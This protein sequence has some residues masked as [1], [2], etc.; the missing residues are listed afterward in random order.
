MYH[1]GLVANFTTNNGCSVDS[2][3]TAQR[4]VP[5]IDVT[6]FTCNLC[7]H[8]WHWLDGAASSGFHRW[9]G[10]QPELY[11]HTFAHCVAAERNATSGIFE[12][13]T[14]VCDI[15]EAVF[16]CKTGSCINFL[17]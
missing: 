6:I 4:T 15:R 2:E 12:W 9:A 17:L 8:R 16:V 3:C 14:I 11:S 1:V 10:N 7:R 5:L 13:Q